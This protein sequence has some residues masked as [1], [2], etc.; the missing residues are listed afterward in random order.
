MNTNHD[1]RNVPIYNANKWN[2]VTAGE[3]LD[4]GFKAGVVRLAKSLITGRDLFANAAKEEALKKTNCTA[5]KVHKDVSGIFANIY[6]KV[7]GKKLKKV[8]VEY[9]QT[10]QSKSVAS[11]AAPILTTKREDAIDELQN[12]K[13]SLKANVESTTSELNRILAER[14]DLQYN[15]LYHSNAEV[16]EKA[17]EVSRPYMTLVNPLR[18]Q[19]KNLRIKAIEQKK[20][21]NDKIETESDDVYKKRIEGLVDADLSEAKMSVEGLIK[22]F[23]DDVKTK[24]AQILYTVHEGGKTNRDFVRGAGANNTYYVKSKLLG[25]V[26]ASELSTGSL[27]VSEYFND[28]KA[29]VIKRSGAK[30]PDGIGAMGGLAETT[31]RM[32]PD[33]NEEEFNKGTPAV[34][35]Y[36][37]SQIDSYNEKIDSKKQKFNDG[38]NKHAIKTA[39]LLLQYM[40]IKHNQAEGNLDEVKKELQDYVDD[41]E[42]NEN[43]DLQ[44]H[45]DPVETGKKA[46]ARETNEEA[47]GDTKLGQAMAKLRKQH[48]KMD[49]SF[50]DANNIL[51]DDNFFLTMRGITESEAPAQCVSPTMFITDVEEAAITQFE[52]EIADIKPEDAKYINAISHGEV[53]GCQVI[54]LNELRRRNGVLKGKLLSEQV[55]SDPNGIGAYAYRYPHEHMGTVVKLTLSQIATAIKDKEELKSVLTKLAK[56]DQAGVFSDGRNHQMSYLAS[57]ASM[58]R[59][60]LEAAKQKDATVDIKKLAYKL[61][62]DEFEIKAITPEILEAMDTASEGVFKEKYPNISLYK[63]A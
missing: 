19:F 9:F 43:G 21:D 61:L 37:K 20:L 6:E 60:D 18:E 47:G 29:I 17:L 51:V 12:L 36:L 40:D 32:F 1:Y 63:I 30:G 35:T 15:E 38:V 42:F 13:K 2:Q 25:T 27:K 33:F 11:V 14:K 5:N 49:K 28:S 54:T 26:P 39:E 41:I 24:R 50:G 48:G 7:T 46:A 57:A 59:K 23:I 4:T 10:T 22:L 45:T 3:I 34:K 16:Q 8:T 52:N 62:A 55:T 58:F 44:I 56:E 31:R 53:A